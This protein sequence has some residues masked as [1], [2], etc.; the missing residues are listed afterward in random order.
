ML[1]AANM[2][3]RMRTNTRNAEEVQRKQRV[4]TQRAYRSK[5]Y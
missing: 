1:S 5:L 4:Q 3:V 2:V